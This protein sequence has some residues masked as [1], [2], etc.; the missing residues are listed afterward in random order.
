MVYTRTK[1]QTEKSLIT[2]IPEENAFFICTMSSLETRFP[3]GAVRGL[4]RSFG[5]R[6]FTSSALWLKA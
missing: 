5:G 2:K 4:R 3:L 1:G 6:H